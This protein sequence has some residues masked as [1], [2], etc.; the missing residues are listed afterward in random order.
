MKH[1]SYSTPQQEHQE[2]LFQQILKHYRYISSCW[3][4]LKGKGDLTTDIGREPVVAA[5]GS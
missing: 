2:D 3:T 1:P 4:N 5:E